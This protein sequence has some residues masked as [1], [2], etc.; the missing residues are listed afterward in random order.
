MPDEYEKFMETLNSPEN[1]ANLD[2]KTFCQLTYKAIHT[3]GY[4]NN[5]ELIPLIQNLYIYFRG[6]NETERMKVYESIVHEVDNNSISVNGFLPF[7]WEDTS[8]FIVSTAVI[9]YCAYRPLDNDDPLTAVK[10]VIAMIVKQ[11]GECRH[12]L[13]GGLLCLGDRRVNNLL[14]EIKE[15]LSPKE[16]QSLATIHTGILYIS[17]FEFYMDWLEEL[18]GN[19]EDKNFGSLASGLILA[20]RQAQNLQKTDEPTVIDHERVFPSPK[21]VSPSNL[22]KSHSFS[23]YRDL[24]T[25]R[26][27]GIKDK[28]TGERVMPRVLEEWGIPY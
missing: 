1:W 4:T 27:L 20:L 8:S 12:G 10:E 3:Y 9:D 19:L 28:E 23:D 22:N 25:P 5:S 7:L 17:T 13:F 6:K 2:D 18:S 16:I 26:L 11:K 24:I 21:D 15:V 14:W